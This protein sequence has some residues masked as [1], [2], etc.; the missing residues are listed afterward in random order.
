MLEVMQAVT[1]GLEPTTVSPKT[2]ASGLST[3]QAVS[4]LFTA[5]YAVLR[6]LSHYRKKS[7]E[8]LHNY[9]LLKPQ[10]SDLLH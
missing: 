2:K 5:G 1:A 8:K 3:H 7:L 4:V 10:N 9:G 6:L